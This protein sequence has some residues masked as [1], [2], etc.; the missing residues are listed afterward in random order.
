MLR[1]ET[2]PPDEYACPPDAQIFR[3]LRN[4]RFMG[5]QLIASCK[6]VRMMG[7]PACLPPRCTI[8]NAMLAT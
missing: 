1:Y 5:R 7:W 2:Y 8:D 6:V 3:R 4:V